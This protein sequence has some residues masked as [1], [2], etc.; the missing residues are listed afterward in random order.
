MGMGSEPVPD[1][2][3]TA[4]E[5]KVDDKLERILALSPVC[6]RRHTATEHDT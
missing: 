2:G 1:D 5:K 6:K 3:S 4:E